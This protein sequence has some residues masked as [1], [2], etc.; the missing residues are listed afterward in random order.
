MSEQ[1]EFEI[2]K[3][4]GD[5]D[6]IDKEL[7]KK[8]ES[9]QKKLRALD[10]LRKDRDETDDTDET[11]E[12]MDIDDTNETKNRIDRETNIRTVF[13]KRMMG[14][15]DTMTKEEKRTAEILEKEVNSIIHTLPHQNKILDK[16]LSVYRT[17]LMKVG[18]IDK[19]IML[20]NREVTQFL[21]N[22]QNKSSYG[23]AQKNIIKLNYIGDRIAMITK[24]SKLKKIFI[25]ATLLSVGALKVAILFIVGHKV[26][27]NGYLTHKLGNITNIMNGHHRTLEA[28]FNDTGNMGQGNYHSN[29]DSGNINLHNEQVISNKLSNFQYRF[30]DT[31]KLGKIDNN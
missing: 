29:T 17:D 11:D 24:I 19:L 2:E 26:I 20:G 1:I 5:E 18:H 6:L 12:F 15:K 3:T 30:K 10:K 25:A 28:G 22:S 27:S 7:F 14:A 4:K 23:E 9:E 8:E 21:E 16:Y 13:I 31:P